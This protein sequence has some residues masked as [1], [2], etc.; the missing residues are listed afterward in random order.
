M[1]VQEDQFIDVQ[2]EDPPKNNNS[3]T[4]KQSGGQTYE[5]ND[6]FDDIMFDM[7]APNAK[8]TNSKTKGQPQTPMTMQG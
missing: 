7:T 1:P 2:I 3:S 4:N 8:T 6:D 5:T